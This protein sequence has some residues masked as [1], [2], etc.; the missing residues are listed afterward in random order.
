[1]VQYLPILFLMV[2][3]GL[4]ASGSFIASQ[5][6]APHRPTRAK[7]APYECGIV[8]EVEPGERFPVKFY[9]V[10]MIFIILDVEIIFLY[11]FVVVFRELGP[12]GLGVMGI[13]L[14]T[15]LVPFAYLLSTGAL[16]WGTLARTPADIGRGVLRSTGRG[17]FERI[18]DPA[19]PD[20]EREDEAA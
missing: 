14:L 4:F 10:A 12:Y 16:D 15:L 20:D 7:S 1:M 19:R 5:L 11:P 6:L 9:L 3:V 13:F 2:V 8:A 17:S 18:G